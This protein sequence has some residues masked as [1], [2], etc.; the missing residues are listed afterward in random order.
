V[1]VHL[2]LPRTGR[3]P[4][5]PVIYVPGGGAY[6][7][8]TSEGAVNNPIGGFLVRTGRA[9]VLPV[10]KG[11]Y[12]RTEDSPLLE[13]MLDSSRWR[14]VAVATVKD[15]SRTIDYLATRPDLASDRIGYLG[16]SRGAAYGPV[17]LAQEARVKAAVLL[18]PGF[19]R[20]RAMPEVHPIN[21]APRMKQPALVLNG[22]WDPIFPEESSQIPF[23]QALGTPE[24][25]KRRLVYPRGHN[26]PVNDSR[27]E[28]IDWFDKHLGPV[29]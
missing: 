21:F 13:S 1:T 4:Y 17:F 7:V 18:I 6:T 29:R 12:E 2:L 27:R 15:L 25:L 23:F 9:L 11:T 19:H 16:N 10:V 22:R 14:D 20:A 28:T 8:R 26:L 3:P 5:Q 24:G